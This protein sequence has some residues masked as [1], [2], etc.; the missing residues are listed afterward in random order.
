M[1]G[2][3]DD[4]S[5]R[6]RAWIIYLFVGNDPIDNAKGSLKRPHLPETDAAATLGALFAPKAPSNELTIIM[7]NRPTNLTTLQLRV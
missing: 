3:D 1:A 4:S 7:A 6:A 5:C 2:V